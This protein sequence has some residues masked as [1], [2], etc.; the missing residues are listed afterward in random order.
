MNN[1]LESKKDVVSQLVRLGMERERAYIGA[2]CTNK[3]IEELKKDNDFI[4]DLDYQDIALEESLLKALDFGIN[5]AVKKGN[6]N[7]VQWK[8]SKHA[9]KWGNTKEDE[10]NS[11][12]GKVHVYVPDNGR[13]K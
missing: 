10:I 12:I 4:C 6:T 3:E 7:A 1:R 5:I 11:V 9:K 13:E 2:A 8:L